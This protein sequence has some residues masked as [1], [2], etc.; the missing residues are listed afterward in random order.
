ME[1]N[2]NLISPQSITK[3]VS[4]SL[5]PLLWH[6]ARGTKLCLPNLAQNSALGS[7][8]KNSVLILCRDQ[9]WSEES[10]SRREGCEGF[11]RR[12]MS[13]KIAVRCFQSKK[14][15]AGLQ[16]KRRT[17]PDKNASKLGQVNHRSHT[18]PRKYRPSRVRDGNISA[19]HVRFQLFQS[20]WQRVS[21]L[22]EVYI[23]P[24]L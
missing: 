4:V 24:V 10:S 2:V 19:G 20:R 22:S 1:G 3:L 14:N 6:L 16:I 21:I 9:K 7:W 17:L 8:A 13:Q 15:F 11:F 12:R 23:N 18:L 5:V